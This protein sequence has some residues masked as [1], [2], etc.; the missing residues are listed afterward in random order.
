[1][2]LSPTCAAVAQ[3]SNSLLL[4]VGSGYHMLDYQLKNGS[5]NSNI[6]FTLNAEYCYYFCKKWGIS[7]GVGV[8]FFKSNSTLNLLTKVADIDSDG[9]AYELRTNYSNWKEKQTAYFIDIPLALT[10]K[11]NMGSNVKLLASVGGKLSIPVNATYK[12]TSGSITTTGYYSQWN[13]ELSDLPEQGFTTFTG[14]PS[15]DL[16]LRT[17]FS[18]LADIGT[19]FT[20]SKATSIYVGGYGSYGLNNILKTGTKTIYQK[21]GTYNGILSSSQTDNLKPMTVGIKLGLTWSL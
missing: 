9:D 1:M 18:L 7:T 6:G 12:A 2:I 19:T 20:V 15:G 4:S 17:A 14:R 11:Q 10:F 3:E 16:S 13:V 8:Q 21:D 5:T